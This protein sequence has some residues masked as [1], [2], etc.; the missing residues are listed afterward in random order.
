MSRPFHSS[1]KLNRTAIFWALFSQLVWVPLLFIDTQ[2]RLTS[3]VKDYDFSAVAK[4]PKQNLPEEL[5]SSGKNLASV[6]ARFNTHSVASRENTGI[7]LNR[8]PFESPIVSPPAKELI[9]PTSTSSLTFSTIVPPT[10]RA[11][12]LSKSKVNS[13]PLQYSIINTST[14]TT[15][16]PLVRQLFTSSELLGGALTLQDINEPSIPP[17]ARAER[18]KWERTGDP[19]APLPEIWREPMRKAL[20][21][22]TNSAKSIVNLKKS[23][24]LPLQVLDTARIIHIPST[25]VRRS[26]EV[27]LALQSDGTV[28]ILNLPDDPAILEE[29]QR[30]SVKQKP[31]VPGRVKP[32]VVHLHAVPQLD[33]PAAGNSTKLSFSKRKPSDPNEIITPTRLS[34][35]ATLP[36][37]TP[38][39]PSAVNSTS[40]V[41]ESPKASESVNSSLSVSTSASPSETVPTAAPVH[42]SAKAPEPEVTPPPSVVESSSSA[43]IPPPASVISENTAPSEE[44]GQ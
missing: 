17:L 18:A 22:L 1:S 15:T 26:T 30:W 14:R 39:V 21:A 41:P 13:E 35:Q 37:Q 9:V 23:A 34:S 27:P 19:L 5:L 31:P 11:H 2:D 36:N 24:K 7:V 33:S 12:I 4:L 43:D 29:I 16:Y 10:G 38:S 44:A 25:Q 20:S 40:S 42:E 8:I 6:S 28:D 3:K 32:A